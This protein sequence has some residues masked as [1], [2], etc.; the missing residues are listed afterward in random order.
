MATLSS[1]LSLRWRSGPRVVWDR[2]RRQFP[3][4]SQPGVIGSR[5][6]EALGDMRCWLN[7]A[8]RS[9]RRGREMPSPCGPGVVSERSPE[10]LLRRRSQRTLNWLALSPESRE[11][12]RLAVLI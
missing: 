7:H 2:P 5:K 1:A 11:T 4:K 12:L 9:C 6:A 10:C 8:G 3:C